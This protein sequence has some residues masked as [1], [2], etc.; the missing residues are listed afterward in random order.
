MSEILNNLPDNVLSNEEKQ[1]LH[2]KI[3]NVA[4]DDI[5]I[6]DVLNK[7]WPH[8]TLFTYP[9]F[10]EEATAK[11]FEGDSCEETDYC[12][13]ILFKASEKFKEKF[14]RYPGSAV[15]D[16]TKD[17][18]EL[19]NMAKNIIDNYEKKPYDLTSDKLDKDLVYE[20]C[21]MGRSYFPPAVSIVGSMASQEIIKMI[22]YQF[23]TV[24]N[25]IIYNGVQSSLGCLTI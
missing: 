2:N 17:I 16:F 19:A 4:P 6:V 11:N 9:K 23:K 21:R 22:T 5:D 15:D 7:N 12:L 8:I 24:N 25:T 3:N 10:E 18:E 1:T 20:F 14:Q 13:Y